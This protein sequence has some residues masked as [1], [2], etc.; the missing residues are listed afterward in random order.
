[1]P[2]SFDELLNSIES[3][4]K[5][6]TIL[7]GKPVPSVADALRALKKN[8]FNSFFGK[9]KKYG[10]DKN[11]F[12]KEYFKKVVAKILFYTNMLVKE[13]NYTSS[14]LNVLPH[15]DLFMEKLNQSIRYARIMCPSKYEEAVDKYVTPA[16]T[17]TRK[18]ARQHHNDNISVDSDDSTSFR[19]CGKKEDINTD[20]MG[21]Y[22]QFLLGSEVNE[23]DRGPLQLIQGDHMHSLF[24]KLRGTCKYISKFQGLWRKWDC[25]LRSTRSEI[26]L[27]VPEK[28]LTLNHVL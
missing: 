13:K 25:I 3:A 1:M 2:Q 19:K 6:T 15:C 12:H 20:Y 16:K 21:R 5:K 23:N 22:Y 18:A 17:V 9:S 10:A 11:L 27:Q 4:I 8:E 26:Y 28:S 14:S 24:T 7:N